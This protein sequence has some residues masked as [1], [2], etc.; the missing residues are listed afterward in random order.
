MKLMPKKLNTSIFLFFLIVMLTSCN[1]KL[2]QIH[3]GSSRK[4]VQSYTRMIMNMHRSTHA[5]LITAAGGD[6]IMFKG[7]HANLPMEMLWLFKNDKCVYQEYNIHC[8]KCAK[9]FEADLINTKDYQ[10]QTKDS[11]NFT[12]TRYPDVLLRKGSRV[13]DS[14]TCAFITVRQLSRK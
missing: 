14:M 1:E 9:Q 4:K 8:S 3:I 7:Y 2:A 13:L 12:S 10:F 11:I 5:G 6:T